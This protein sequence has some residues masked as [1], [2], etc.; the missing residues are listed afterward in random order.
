MKG[1]IKVTILTL[2]CSPIYS[3]NEADVL[4]YSTTDVFGSARFEA[5][6]GSF[7][8]LGADISAIQINPASMG[9]FSSSRAS[10]SLN[11]SFATNKG[12]YNATETLSNGNK[13]AVSAVGV[14]LTSDLSTKNVGRRYSQVTLGYTRLKN[15]ANTKRYEGQNFNSLLDVLAA[16][17]FG[18]DPQYIYDERPFTTGLAYDVFAVDYDVGTGEYF[19][20]LTMGDMYHEREIITNGGIGEFHIGY[21]ENYMNKIY[22]GA[23]LGIRRVN[24]EERFLHNERLLDTT[25]VSLR[26]FDYTY[27]QKTSGTGLNLKL[28][29]LYLPV[30]ELRV[31]LAFETPTV[32][33]LKDEWTNDMTALHDYGME[34]VAP[35]HVPNGNF[36]YRIKT[37]MKLRGSLAYVIGMKMAVNV[38][39]E[40]ARLPGGRLKSSSQDEYLGI[41]YDFKVENEEVENQY[42]TV[43]NTRIGVEYMIFNDFYLRGGIA[44]LPQPYKKEIG[45]NNKMNMTYSGG[46][47]WENRFFQIDVSYRILQLNEDYYA[48]DPSRI[49]NKTQ[50]KTHIHNIVVTAGLK[51]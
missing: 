22:Y 41:G 23:S 33:R 50:F 34:S 25:G 44:L 38:D 16:D 18:V 20:R 39:L 1:I 47:G 6:A 45:N 8:G 5:M 36:E 40:M 3:Q 12:I 43:L 27:Y 30:D 46:I 48:F 24:Y 11:G 51:F 19:S 2:L 32:I 13:F 37:P 28:G 15:F 9:R 31:G 14:V 21:S 4:R 17:G 10:F 7:G 29:F 49:E 35:E 26:S 42:R